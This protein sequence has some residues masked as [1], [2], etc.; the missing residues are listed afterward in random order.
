M[1]SRVT[2][3]WL[4]FWS[5][6][7]AAPASTLAQST[8]PVG[9]VTTLQGTATVVH[10]ATP[11][12]AQLRFKDEVFFRDRITT[13]DDSVARILLGGKAIV[14]VR[15]R[16]AL[17]ITELPG[18]STID[19]T[20]G[21]VAVAVAKER[22][23]TGESVDILT[24]NAVAGIRG[25]VVIAEVSPGVAPTSTFTVLQGTIDVT[26]LDAVSRQAVA[27]AIKVGHLQ[28]VGVTALVPPI[29]RTITPETAE[30]LAKDFKVRVE[31]VSPRAHW[32]VTS[33]QIQQALGHTAAFLSPLER[34]TRLRTTRQTTAATAQ[35]PTEVRGARA[36]AQVKTSDD[37]GAA[38]DKGSRAGA[39]SGGSNAPVSSSA[40]ARASGPTASVGASAGTSAGIPRSTASGPLAITS[41]GP[42]GAARRPSHD[43]L[44]Q[45]QLRKIQRG[46]SPPR[47]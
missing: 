41:S 14:T 25:T 16:S 29:T 5:A 10:A 20:T 38:G 42:L 44:I 9:I 19:V 26:P 12:A 22:M 2:T 39:S 35:H 47:R 1:E 36:G 8:P 18:S 11:Q 46:A 23:K 28:S 43:A 7:V 6:V 27:P 3:V 15:E 17:T 4:F 32:P 45:E 21:R 34:Q 13:G 37:H 30:R 24:P 40:A 31:Q 33:A